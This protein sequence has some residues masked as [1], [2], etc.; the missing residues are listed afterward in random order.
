MA[1]C[2][3]DE[4]QRT[5]QTEIKIFKSFNRVARSCLERRLVEEARTRDPA[6]NHKPTINIQSHYTV[7]LSQQLRSAKRRVSADFQGNF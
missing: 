4:I 7:A 3:S 5:F 1:C 6:L 2:I